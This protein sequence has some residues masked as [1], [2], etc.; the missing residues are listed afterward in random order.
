MRKGPRKCSRG[1]RQGQPDKRVRSAVARLGEAGWKKGLSTRKAVQKTFGVAKC[2]N[3]FQFIRHAPHP[4]VSFGFFCVRPGG[5]P[6]VI[7]R[8]SP[9]ARLPFLGGSDSGLAPGTARISGEK[10][11]ALWLLTNGGNTCTSAY[12]IPLKTPFSVIM[13]HDLLVRV[14]KST[15]GTPLTSG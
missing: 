9:G 6:G 1:S 10:K 3:P 5:D 13:Q 11:L 4:H 12:I 7:P 8:A 14:R 15:S 2:G